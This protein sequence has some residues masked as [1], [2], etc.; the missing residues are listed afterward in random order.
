MKE[1]DV[2]YEVYPE[3]KTG[4]RPPQRIKGERSKARSFIEEFTKRISDIYSP[5]GKKK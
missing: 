1:R 3:A 5:N 2:G 4:E